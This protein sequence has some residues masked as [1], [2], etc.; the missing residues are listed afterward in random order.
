MTMEMETHR[1]DRFVMI[2]MRGRLDV[3]ENRFRVHIQQLLA[4]GGC[5]FALNL[6]NLD[7]VDAS[8]LGQLIACRSAIIDA[9]GSMVLVNPSDRLRKLLHITKLDTVFAVWIEKD[10][11][12]IGARWCQSSEI[13]HS[14]QRQASPGLINRRRFAVAA[15]GR[16]R[17]S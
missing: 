2:E 9:G 7:Y 3:L 6:T 1:Q 17:D 13:H 4:D 16:R 15:S 14:K 11:V 10:A 8:G 12:S 5:H